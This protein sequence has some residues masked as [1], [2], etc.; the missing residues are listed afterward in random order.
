V[1][2]SLE[3]LAVYQLYHNFFKPY[4]VDDIELR[5]SSHAEIAGI[6]GARLQQGLENIFSMRKFFSHVRLNW[7]QMLVWARMVGTLD[8]NDGVFWPKYVWM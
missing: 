4:R 2:S 3:R 1:N 6:G 7:S 8:K 5:E